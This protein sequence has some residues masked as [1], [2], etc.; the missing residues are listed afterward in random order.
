MSLSGYERQISKSWTVVSGTVEASEVF[1]AL[2]EGS[3]LEVD[4]DEIL[5]AEELSDE[6]DAYEQE[7]RYE[8]CPQDVPD[9]IQEAAEEAA[10]EH[11][12]TAAI[13]AATKVLNGDTFDVE[14]YENPELR[15]LLEVAG[16]Y[17]GTHGTWNPG[18]GT[19]A[20]N[21][22]LQRMRLRLAQIKAELAEFEAT[23]A[24]QKEQSAKAE[25]RRIVAEIEKATKEKEVLDQVTELLKAG[26]SHYEV[27]QMFPVHE[28]AIG[29]LVGR[30]RGQGVAITSG[31]PS[32][33]TK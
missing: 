7:G 10:R 2:L 1:P 26:K 5:A 13:E 27:R 4:V 14:D 33:Q 16:K 20:Q 17:C 8:G 24:A 23:E 25:V 3:D 19:P 31:F 30:L 11:F 29:A 12:K 22:P 18:W 15:I 32:V 9:H 6:D 21:D 28:S